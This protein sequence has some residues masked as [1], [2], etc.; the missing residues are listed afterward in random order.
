MAKSRKLG[1]FHT[2]ANQRDLLMK[3][4]ILLLCTPFLTAP[5]PADAASGDGTE[6]SAAEYRWGKTGHRVVGEVAA[7]YLTRRARRAV[8]R[9]LGPESL[10]IASTWMDEIK[11]DSAYDHTHD[12]HWVTIPD[13]MR[14][15]ETE[16]NPNGDLIRT[17]ERLVAELKAGDL[18][19]G[20][21]ARH[22]KMLIHL[23]GDIHQPLHVGTGED[24]GGNEAEVQWFSEPSNLH[25]VWDSEMIDDSKLSYTEL[26]RAVNHPGK[27]EIRRWQASTVRDWAYESMELREEVY[28]LPEERRLGYRYTFENWDLLQRQLLK[29][30]VRL[31]G[32]LND[33]YG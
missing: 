2:L 5:L 20:R 19:P 31:A 11:S 33:I 1:I 8:D 29:A 21:E 24:R 12:W 17:L 9:V 15:E 10:A 23:V 13:G 4:I 18:S 22:L 7:D 14:Y 6:I 16:K 27:A 32:V 28:D 25:R 30:G 26:T 3:A